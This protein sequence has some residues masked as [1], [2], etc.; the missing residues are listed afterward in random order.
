MPEEDNDFFCDPWSPLPRWAGQLSVELVQAW[1]LIAMDRRGTS[2]PYCT[3]ALLQKQADQGPFEGAKVPLGRTKTA[4][5]TLN[6]VWNETIETDLVSEEKPSVLLELWDEDMLGS[7]DF[8][9]RAL[10]PA[11]YRD[12]ECAFYLP[13]ESD[14]TR[15]KRTCEGEILAKIK[16]EHAHV[17]KSR[18][19]WPQ[20]TKIERLPWTGMLHVKC[21]SA[22]GLRVADTAFLGAGSSDPYAKVTVT[23]GQKVLPVEKTKTIMKTLDPVWNETL[24]FRLRTGAQPSILLEVMDWDR[25]PKSDD[26]LGEIELPIPGEEN[27]TVTHEM[28]LLTNKKKNKRDAKGSMKVEVTFETATSDAEE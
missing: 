12:G 3:V 5:K 8:L 6:P 23:C 2:D 15:N 4:K 14:I 17:Q 27:L 16:F 28:E 1:D 21:L 9:G 11:P 22:S 26:F 24:H 19:R 20:K 18:H 7:K 25:G 13:L 10:L